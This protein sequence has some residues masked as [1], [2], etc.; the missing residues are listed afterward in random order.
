MLF[1]IRRSFRK[2]IHGHPAARSFA[3][4]KDPLH[5]WDVNKTKVKKERA[6]EVLQETG[7]ARG[8]VGGEMTELSE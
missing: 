6:W 3:T 2:K 4:K 1:N 5:G 7:S 8:K